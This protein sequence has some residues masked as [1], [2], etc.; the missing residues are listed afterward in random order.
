[1]YLPNESLIM[2]KEF[3]L[4]YFKFNLFYTCVTRDVQNGHGWQ[5]CSR[6]FQDTNT[7]ININALENE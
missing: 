3:K 4:N 5:C 2:L 6:D 7:Q 1:M